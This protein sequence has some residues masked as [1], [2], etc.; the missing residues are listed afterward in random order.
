[1]DELFGL[2]GFERF[3]AGSPEKYCC[4]NRDTRANDPTTPA[5]IANGSG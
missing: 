3:G 4:E 5:S 2:S 1:M